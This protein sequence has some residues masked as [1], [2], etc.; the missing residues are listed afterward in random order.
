MCRHLIYLSVD[1][2]S[3]VTELQESFLRTRSAGEMNK[4]VF[5]NFLW[6]LPSKEGMSVRMI[7]IADF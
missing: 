7:F 3:S 4:N 5:E 2:I 1:G 6:L